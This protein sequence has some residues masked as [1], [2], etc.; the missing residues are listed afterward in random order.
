MTYTTICYLK[1]YKSSY[2]FYDF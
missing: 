2:W 1:H